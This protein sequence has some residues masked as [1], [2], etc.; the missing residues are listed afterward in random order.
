MTERFHM[1]VWLHRLCTPRGRSR[2]LAGGVH[3][4]E[5]TMASAADVWRFRVT[6]LLC[7]FG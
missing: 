3:S 5:L 4:H 1:E 6:H 7:D 2:N